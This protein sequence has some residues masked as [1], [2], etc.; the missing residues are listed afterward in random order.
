[1]Q[2]GNDERRFGMTNG[3]ALLA[4]VA[5]GGAALLWAL[6]VAAYRI[7]RADAFAVASATVLL[8]VPPL[9][10]YYA[11]ME[12]TEDRLPLAWRIVVTYALAIVWLVVQRMAIYPAFRFEGSIGESAANLLLLPAFGIAVWFAVRSFRYRRRLVRALEL[13]A[14]TELR[15]LEAQLAPH[16]LFNML[17]AVYSVLLTDAEKAIPLFLSMSDAL[18][19]VV[20]R[21]RKRWIPL[22]EEID[23]IQNYA[24]LE[25]AR[26]PERAAISIDAQGDLDVPVPPMLLATLFE[27]AVKHGRF[28]DGTLAIAVDVRIEET[29]M[30]FAVVNRFP[31]STSAPRGM[32]VGQANLRSR[33]ELLYARRGRLLTQVEGDVYRATIEIA[34]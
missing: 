20:D 28:A 1:M 34:Q 23:F 25:R 15:L 14:Q 4:G 12:A 24:V 6:L 30:H 21:T 8:V 31:S 32:G 19:H 26:N 10:S 5:A 7:D 11:L 27:N 3:R 29:K 22:H 2:T 18:R 17:N 13:Q 33:L 16:T 9:V